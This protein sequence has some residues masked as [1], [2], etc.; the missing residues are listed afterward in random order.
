[1]SDIPKLSRADHAEIERQLNIPVIDAGMVIPTEDNVARVFESE[2]SETLRYCNQ[3]GKWLR[4]D[5]YRWLTEET[6]LAFHYCRMLARKHNLTNAPAPAKASF[7]G[8]VERLC[9]SSRVFATE[10]AQWDTQHMLFNT[11]TSTIDLK[12]GESR[13]HRKSDHITRCARVAPSLGPRP[14][15]DMFMRDITL[16]D[17][18]LIDY[19]QRSL[20][21]CLSG[22]IQDNF[23]LFWYG[24][25]QNGKNTLG[26]LV[27]WI[28]G[29]YAK[30]I[31]S[32]TLMAH[33]SGPQHPTDLASLR[34]VRLATSS[35]V[36]E[37]A[38]FN[39]QRIK[40]L[41]GDTTIAARFMRQDYFEFPRTH[42]HLIYGNHRP[43]LRT[44]DPAMRARLN[45]APFKA[46][47]PPQ[48]RDPY[49]AA[50][51]R[52]EAPQ[53]LQWLI[54]GH[55]AWLHDGYLK[56]C[57]AVQ[58]ETDSYFEAQSTPDMWVAEC[59]S[60]GNGERES[61]KDLYG[62]YKSWKESRGEGVISQTRWGE[63]M[64]RY[65]KKQLHG[66]FFYY[67]IGILGSINAP[68]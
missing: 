7:A 20:G 41:T 21:A 22:A 33:R 64:Q 49:M 8:G 39:E 10:A 53:I 12:T 24:T 13:N 29:D 60:V 54:D 42:K 38:H 28:F 59:C 44:V 11:P 1:M 19:H 31:P 43:M 67:G 56:K 4:W 37:G 6:L 65:D 34:G 2:H 63:W 36:E 48:A 30:A 50:K 47:F 51:L 35:E 40:S 3:W 18:A 23:L 32:E 5:S 26:D 45:I 25:G 57:S 16:H 61:A 14:V 66:R 17:E 9:R 52:D 46:H 27:E 55:E 62:S 15:F 68:K 58:E